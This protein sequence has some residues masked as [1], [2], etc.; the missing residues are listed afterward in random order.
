M[1]ACGLP[2]PAG[3]VHRFDPT[4]L[5]AGGQSM[6]GMYTNMIGAV[7]G[8]YG[9][10]VPTGAGGFWNMMILD[11]D[12]VVGARGLLA[13]ILGVEPEPLSFMHPTLALLGLGWEIAD[14]GASMARIARRPLPGITARHVYQPIGLD[15]RYFPTPVFDAA[16]LAYGN[17]QAGEL[18]WQGT[19]DALAL[20]D[21]GGLVAYPISANRPGPAGAPTT[22]VVVQY[23][24]GGIVD[25][26]QVYRQL[27]AVR[28]QYGCFLASYLRDGVPTVY[29]P[30]AES[31]PCP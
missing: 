14:P 29:A 28:Y 24:D 16:A 4:K 18:V 25:G 23:E 19:Q 17:H 20:D 2:S 1:A 15:D 13:G 26:H 6:G 30:A 9:A 5:V 12:I 22:A 31:A 7:E 8:R 10:L 21:L 27:P 3:G 11:T